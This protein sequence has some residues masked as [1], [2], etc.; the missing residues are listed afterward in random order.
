MALSKLILSDFSDSSVVFG[1]NWRRT[2]KATINH[3]TTTT[4]QSI[5]KSHP[6]RHASFKRKSCSYTKS[7]LAKLTIWCPHLV[8]PSAVMTHWPFLSDVRS[9]KNGRVGLFVHLPPTCNSLL[10]TVSFVDF[11]FDSKKI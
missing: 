9:S 8:W 6:S 7:V 5:L 10:L 1:C 4:F 3:S 2:H 11:F